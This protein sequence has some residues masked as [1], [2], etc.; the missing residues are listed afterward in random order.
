MRRE[1]TVWHAQRRHFTRASIRLIPLL[2][3]A[4]VLSEGIS[5]DQ[6]QVRFVWIVNRILG[7]T[8]VACSVASP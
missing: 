3:A 6:A 7:I 5:P 4:Q 2:A 1:H 8:P